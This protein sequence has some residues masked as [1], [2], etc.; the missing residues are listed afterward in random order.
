[1]FRFGQPNNPMVFPLSANYTNDILHK[2]VDKN[3][4]YIVPTA[5]G[6]DLYRYSLNWGSSWSDWLQYDGKNK[7]LVPQLWTGTKA[8]QWTGE[9][10]ILNFWSEKTGSS[11]HIQHSDLNRG[12]QPPRRWPHA[13]IMGS[14]NQYGYDNG[15]KNTMHLDRDGLW[16]FDMMAEWPTKIIL[17]VWGMNLDGSPD[18]SKAFGDVDGD[19][20][21]DLIP[22]DSLAYNVINLTSPPPMPY[23]GFRVIAND[24]NYNYRLEPAGSAWNQLVLAILIGIIPAI[25]GSLGVWLFKRSFYKV[26]FNRIGVS[27]KQSFMA[28]L[29]KL[30]PGTAA[31]SLAS[32]Q[33]FTS[34]GQTPVMAGAMSTALVADTGAPNR[35]TVLIATMEYEIE[36]WNIKVKIGGLGVMASL[37]AKNL[38]HQNLIWVVPC[39]GDVEYP[40]D[41]PGEVITVQILDH[42]YEIEVQYHK[43]RN[44]T[45]V[46]LDSPIFRKQT[47]AEPYPARMDD[48]D[49][50]IF[51]SAW[52]TC[53]SKALRRFPVDIYHINDYHG[54]LAPLNLLPRTIPVCLSLHNAEFQG[55]W[56]LRT[57][58][59]MDEICRVFNLPED[60]VKKYVQFGEVFNLLHAAA[61][62]LHIHQKGFG[63]VGV[64]KKY[65]KR[66]FAR[67][68][69]FWGLKSIGALPNPD[70][71]DTGEWNKKAAKIEANAVQVDEA[72]QIERRNL[73]VQ[74]QEWAGLQVDPTVSSSFSH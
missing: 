63:A 26:K 46:L 62:Y 8:Q 40:T 20:V 5:P 4:L 28:T 3:D 43:L 53:I 27:E 64:S 70:P 32:S 69:I 44:I 65:G 36:D 6:A 2:N 24:G 16:K 73:R 38:G 35:R 49:S 58:K 31:T 72:S 60:I 30:L 10:V 47:K 54:A 18:K 55:L 12:Q 42:T 56:P 52:N 19:G 59:E 22:P 67:Y 23:L 17:N 50:A 48:L 13:S 61:S 45:F 21:L 34:E 25:T 37:M 15:L 14:W 11:E 41:T 57:D 71:S 66:S 39:V 74:A 51:Y 29:N 9:H 33:S 1:M 7:T 68:P